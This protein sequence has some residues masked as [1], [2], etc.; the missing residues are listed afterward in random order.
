MASS[1]STLSLFPPSPLYPLRS[2]LLAPSSCRGKSVCNPQSDLESLDKVHQAL[3]LCDLSLPPALLQAVSLHLLPGHLCSVQCRCNLHS[4]TTANCYNSANPISSAH[5]AMVSTIQ[6][7]YT[8]P[9]VGTIQS[10]Y[11]VPFVGTILSVYT[12]PLVGTILSVHT[13]PLMGTILSVHT[14]ACHWWV[15]LCRCTR[16]H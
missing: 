6:S 9:L 1:S 10:V 13:V 2:A 12:V 7:V 5:R 14:V 11:T 3:E 8:V 15:P 4:T 16:C